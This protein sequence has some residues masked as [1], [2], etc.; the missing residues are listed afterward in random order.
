[1]NEDDLAKIQVE[2]FNDNDD[3][4]SNRLSQIECYIHIEFQDALCP[5]GAFKTS[6]FFR[7]KS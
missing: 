3:L 4:G 5:S 6:N 7:L 1:M 2:V